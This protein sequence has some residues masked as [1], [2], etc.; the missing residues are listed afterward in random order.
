MHFRSAVLLLLAAPIRSTLADG[1][2]ATAH[3]PMDLDTIAQVV[4]QQTPDEILTERRFAW[5]G[6]F[7]GDLDGDGLD[8]IVLPD[9]AAG[10]LRLIFSE[11][12]WG[13][14]GQ[15][16]P[17]SNGD[18][19]LVLPVGCIRTDGFVHLRGLGDVD[20][21]G[22][23]D[24]GVACPD[25]AVP[26]AGGERRGAGAIWWG[27]PT[28]PGNLAA[29][30]RLLRGQTVLWTGE[31]PNIEF[32][33]GE[34]LGQ[35]LEGLG[36]ID[37][38][39]YDDFAVAGL[40][41][42]T[43][44]TPPVYVF[45]G[46]IDAR[47]ELIDASDAT[48]V[49]R[50][51]A[52]QDCLVPFQLGPMGDVDGDGWADFAMSCGQ[53][54]VSPPN[55]L[56]VAWQAFLGG[57]LRSFVPGVYDLSNRSFGFTASPLAPPRAVDDAD[58][59]DVDGD[60][61]GDWATV[62]WDVNSGLI[63]GRLLQGHPA[64]WQD[65]DLFGG[66]PEDPFSPWAFWPMD[67]LVDGPDALQFAPGPPWAEGGSA[68]V[69]QG[70][71]PDA[72]ISLLDDPDP[73]LWADSSQPPW[74]VRI[75]P[76]GGVS[77]SDTWRLGLGGRGD[78]NGDGVP[79]LLVTSGWADDEGCHPLACGGAWLVLCI[80][81]DGDGLGPCEGDCDDHDP[82]VSPAYREVCD[83]LDHD[84]DGNPGVAD[85]DGD[86]LTACGGDCDDHDAT[87]LAGAEE[88]CA[89]TQD[90]DC[91]GLLPGEDRDGDGALNCED[92]QPHRTAQRPGGTE[93]CDG[94][95]NDCNHM[96]PRDEQDVDQDGFFACASLLGTD[97]DD[98]DPW[99][100]PGRW[101]DCGNSK[102]DDCDG[103]IDEAVDADGDGVS[104]CSGD[105]RDDDPTAFPGAPEACDGQDDDCN[106]IVDDARDRDGDGV[107][108]CRGDC[109]DDDD[110]IAAG[111]TG[112]CDGTDHDCV[113]GADTLDLDGDGWSACAGDC[114]DAAPDRAPTTT[115][116]CDR[117]DNDCDHEVD[118]VWD[119]DADGWA[120]CHGDCDDV[121]ASAFPAPVE[122]DCSDGD[123]GD[124]DGRPDGSELECW[125]PDPPPEPGPRPY[126][127][128]CV[129]CQQGSG[130]A[131]AVGLLVLLPLRSRRRRSRVPGAATTI[132]LLL[133]APS[134]QAAKAEKGV[135]VYL[136]NQ[137]DIGSMASA[138]V[139]AVGIKA[140]QVLH[141]SELLGAAPPHPDVRGAV[142]VLPCGGGSAMDLAAVSNQAL[143]RLIEL[144][145]PTAE[146]A[147]DRAIAALPCADRPVPNR[148]LTELFY[149]RAVARVGQKKFTLADEDFRSVVA[150]SPEFTGDPNFPP[151]VNGRLSALRGE[152]AGGGAASFIV[153]TPP[154]TRAWIDGRDLPAEGMGGLRPGRHLLQIGK[155]RATA[156][157]L[158]D[159]AAGNDAAATLVGDRVRALRD[160]ALH[161]GARRWA[162]AVLG[163]AADESEV[164][165]VAVI[166]LDT[167]QDRLRALY[168]PSI[169][170][171]SWEGAVLAGKGGKIAAAPKGSGQGSTPP[172]SSAASGGADSPR[173]V[174]TGGSTEPIAKPRA[175]NRAAQARSLAE[176][177][178]QD[179]VR[180]R[181][182]AGF[183]AAHPWP[184][185]AIPL[186]LGIR[187]GG[188]FFLDGSAMVA[189][190]RS[191]DAG[192]YSLPVAAV[193]ASWRFD[194]AIIQP[195]VGAAFQVGVDSAGGP[196]T[197]RPGFLV[198]GGFD[199]VPDVKPLLVG[200]DVQAGL[201]G[202]ATFWFA[203]SFGAGVRF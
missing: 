52:G 180:V 71:G 149:H 118:E 197:G 189:L 72:Q 76:P 167:E 156:S 125:T 188:G 111:L 5:G 172:P 11:S 134:V 107:G 109:D 19:R 31:P 20:G 36:D 40:W 160:A 66:D 58:L 81:V 55:S 123:D 173:P 147:L 186:D 59:G 89:D 42:V 6:R 63:A 18:S 87:R 138:K 121:A 108:P 38:D 122:T 165:L 116:W 82:S 92:C 84:C 75:G 155:G 103:V 128:A 135:V 145:H 39:G 179:V 68:W 85:V 159:L 154:G 46:G 2:V 185:L 124:C 201:L 194:T 119:V 196:V 132:L 105:C 69:R 113:P 100:Q 57:H 60:G 99:V 61:L 51:G 144:D 176:S 53:Q 74:L 117:R 120:D 106:R 110:Q 3:P 88:S 16:H 64:P 137:P 157:L 114:D 175:A 191:D 95:D 17:S 44:F 127:L 67:E 79:D 168:R 195:R 101:E 29:P 80:D 174:P 34:I 181:L 1:L 25:Q 158:V 169:D 190:A 102:D 96:I 115:E 8:D 21:D 23:G 22:R 136:A 83:E 199:L 45:R 49:L 129:D 141:V 33:Q 163:R 65:V 130:E 70:D 9:P 62:R 30:D 26:D 35:D 142:G 98:L 184:Y 164:D 170:T 150:L 104:T 54:P 32:T 162:A 192:T 143:D 4:I 10:L 182:G 91:D 126:G 198:R 41:P 161:P 78:A 151:E 15:R 193:G 77:I 97:C 56:N 93:I 177:V 171:F 7:V 133:V 152:G 12:D 178:R 27:R 14:G 48:W 146:G 166:D 140:E 43:P 28:W 47:S 139:A 153:Y 112:G 183:A 90:L 94:L 37:G 200:L 202:R 203:A 148:L 187:L 86:G 131:A 24:L 13:Q 73:S 50:P